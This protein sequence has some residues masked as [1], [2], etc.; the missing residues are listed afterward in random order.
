MKSDTLIMYKSDI[1]SLFKAALVKFMQCRVHAQQYNLLPANSI[2]TVQEGEGH[3]E[4][5]VTCQLESEQP[6]F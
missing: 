6:A 2:V 1:Q 5:I 4:A 3:D